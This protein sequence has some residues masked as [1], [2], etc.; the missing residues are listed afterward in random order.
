M[1]GVDSGPWSPALHGVALALSTLVQEDAPTISAAL[2]SSAGK[3]D[4]RIGFLACFTGIWMGDALLYLLA[5]GFGRPLLARPLVAR[6]VKSDSIQ[7]GERWFE[8]R[9]SWALV[10]SRFVPG[11]R[12]PTYVAAGLLRVPLTQFLSVTAAA[13]LAWTT[14]LFLAAHS[15]GAGAQTVLPNRGAA[16]A[17]AGAGILATMLAWRAL[18]Q[19]GRE[20]VIRHW[21]KRAMTW[22][23]RWA[24]WEFWPAWLFY[25][26]VALNYLRLS[27]R[28]RG[29]TIPTAANPGIFS[30]GLVGES[31]MATLRELHATSPEFTAEAYLIQ[32]TTLEERLQSL[33][34]VRERH[35]ID[36][37]FVL[38]PDV[39]QRGVGVKII[40]HARAAE[41]YLRVATLPV[42]CQRY[43]PGPSEAGIFYYRFP[44]QTRGRIFAITEKIFPVIT[45]DGRRSVEELIWA[46]PRAR[47]IA[48]KYL[49]R[50]RHCRRNVLAVGETVP[51]VESGNH[52]QGC[53]FRDGKH[54]W[55]EVLER[56][57]DEISRKLNGFFIGRYDLRYA[58]DDEL[59]AGHNFEI[60]E[61]NGAASEATSIYDARNSLGAA[62]RTLFRQWDLVF[63]I[64]AA[65]R[66]RGTAT[67]PAAT[68]RRAWFE[69]R[70]ILAQLPVAD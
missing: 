8:Q 64:G 18:V 59:R 19:R 40:R 6:F 49:R 51:L 58:S 28:Y 50:L 41:E 67:T 23:R 56:R 57:I 65:N 37:P 15:L 61:L 43:A 70:R 48:H 36:Y 66:R 1:S 12:L 27:I 30:G 20:R 4:W 16:T 68:L 60:V 11:L 25:T 7:K 13:V 38:K 9:G 2:L 35:R 26:P 46:D 17:L 33:E 31:K 44:D 47:L 54:L 42:V 5:R 55:S 32:G 39:G 21:L 24:H 34:S 22:L 10:F 69:S 52:A 63:A 14:A 45:G 3:L 53:I 29:L 62:Y